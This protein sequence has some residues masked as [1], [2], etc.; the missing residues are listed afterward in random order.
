M[1]KSAGTLALLSSILFACSAPSTSQG[2]SV[3]PSIIEDS[4]QSADAPR[5]I[6]F[7]SVNKIYQPSAPPYPLTAKSDGIH[8]EVLVEVWMN[9]EGIPIKSIALFGPKELRQC[10][11]DYVLA[12]KFA[13][14]L[15]N[16]KP[17]P[18]RFRMV[19]PFRLKFGGI[20]RTVPK[21]LVN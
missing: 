6:P 17:S 20:Y 7:K 2:P 13:P 3:S 10:A 19:M 1:N 12:W 4:L 5:L 11:T 21:E 18:V 15:S 14:V 9:E 16:G 8:G